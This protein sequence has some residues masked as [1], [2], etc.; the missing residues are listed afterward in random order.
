VGVAVPGRFQQREWPI[1]DEQHSTQCGP[2]P[3]DVSFS[4]IGGVSSGVDA[5]RTMVPQKSILCPDS[6]NSDLTCAL[7]GWP[8]HTPVTWDFKS[9]PHVAQRRETPAAAPGRQRQ[10]RPDQGLMFSRF[11][12]V[13][14]CE[15]YDSAD[16]V[17]SLSERG[18]YCYLWE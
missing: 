5:Q 14:R 1:V 8:R 13:E 12:T 2:S 15:P 11:S 18:Q 16:V 4:P 7:Y 17:P 10:W 3:V 6:P 9:Q